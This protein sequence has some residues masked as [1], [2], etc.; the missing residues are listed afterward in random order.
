[1]LR[2]LLSAIHEHHVL[3][4]TIVVEVVS[5]ARSGGQEVCNTDVFTLTLVA[6][7]VLLTDVCGVL[8][9]I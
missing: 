5:E 4:T 2:L 3:F 9:F 6:E 8:T 7:S 1:M